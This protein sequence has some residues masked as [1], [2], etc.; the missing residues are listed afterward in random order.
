M[1][2]KRRMLNGDGAAYFRYSFFDAHFKPCSMFV[3]MLTTSTSNTYL[4]KD[5]NTIYGHYYL[6]RHLF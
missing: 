5:L 1:T 6:A 3:S 4:D 2:E